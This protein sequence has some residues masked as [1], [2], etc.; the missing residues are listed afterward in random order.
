MIFWL[1]LKFEISYRL[2]I[3]SWRIL[4]S[5]TGFFQ[6]C[7]FLM[8]KYLSFPWFVFFL[9]ILFN[10]NGKATV[11]HTPCFGN[12]PWDF[13][14]C[15]HGPK[16]KALAGEE[17]EKSLL[18]NKNSSYKSE[19]RKISCLFVHDKLM[20][21]TAIHFASQISTW[22]FAETWTTL[23]RQLYWTMQDAAQRCES[24]GGGN[25]GAYT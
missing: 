3:I 17:K 18:T 1:V 11:C 21:L 12:A 6:D 22:V 4:V 20:F 15:K 9:K 16:T 19:Y 23:I 5:F 2:V 7:I 24:E 25:W 8:A 14:L 10:V 13:T